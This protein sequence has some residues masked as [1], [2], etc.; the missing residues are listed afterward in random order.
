MPSDTQ[1]ADT[2]LNTFISQKTL[3]EYTF[4]SDRGSPESEL[5]R[6]GGEKGRECIT[7]RMHSTRL[8]EAMQVCVWLTK[9][10]A[11]LPF[12]FLTT[13][14]QKQGFYCAVP[15]DPSRTHIACKKIPQ[16]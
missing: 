4:D 1:N 15:M 14:E 6:E 8:F 5:C 7:L 12:F 2:A 3:A 11:P 10:C 16:N 13:L 9:T